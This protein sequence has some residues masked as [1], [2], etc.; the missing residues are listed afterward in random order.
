MKNYSQCIGKEITEL[1]SGEILNNISDLIFNTDKS[2]LKALITTDNKILYFSDITE[3]KIRIYIKD[4]ILFKNLNECKD[5]QKILNKNISI[6]GTKVENE[7]GVFLGYCENFY[8]NEKTGYLVQIYI[9]YYFFNLFPIKRFLISSTDIIEITE[10]KI[11]VKS[12]NIKDAL[13][14]I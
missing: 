10:K 9:K 7:D 6:L 1:H 3:W 2:K 14:D 8:F 11:I 4:N 13:P 5:I 12:T